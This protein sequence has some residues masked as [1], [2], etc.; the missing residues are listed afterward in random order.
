MLEIEDLESNFF[1][2]LNTYLYS[3]QH[4]CY[5]IYESR[6]ILLFIWMLT[7]PLFRQITLDNI[8][9]YVCKAKKLSQ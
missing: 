8:K 7:C 5:I 3:A 6:G 9:K 4:I 2:Y 1:F